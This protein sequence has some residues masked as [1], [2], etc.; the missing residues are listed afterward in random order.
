MEVNLMQRVIFTRGRP[1]TCDTHTIHTSYL[2]TGW[3]KDIK[4]SLKYT[5]NEDQMRTFLP[6]HFHLQI[7]LFGQ[8]SNNNGTTSRYIFHST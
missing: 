1:L 8:T 2:L 3:Q 7:Q 6:S 5:H 4:E